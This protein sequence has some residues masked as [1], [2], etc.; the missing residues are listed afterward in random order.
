MPNRR[1]LARRKNL[2]SLGARFVSDASTG[3]ALRYFTD[4]HVGIRRISVGKRFIY[5][6][7]HGRRVRDRETLHRI[8]SLVIPPAWID[9]WISPLANG[10]LQSTGRDSRGRKQYL[11]HPRWREV[12]DAAKFDRLLNFAGRLPRLR[13]RLRRDLASKGISREKVL[14]TVVRLLELTSIRVGNEEYARNNGSFGLTT[15]RNHHAQ[16]N[17]ESIR[18]QFRGKSGKFHS[19]SITNP[20]LARVVRKC[21]ELPGHEL[22]EYVDDKGELHEINSGDVNAYLRDVMGEDFTAKD[23]RTWAGTLLASEYL[24]R[25]GACKTMAESNR[26]VKKM[27]KSVAERLGNTPTVCRKSYIHPI[28]IESASQSLRNNASHTNGNGDLRSIQGLHADEAALL[29]LL[30]RAGR[31]SST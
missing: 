24:R 17:G 22:F 19:V 7:P 6:D 2:R 31:R 16:V 9:V 28:V 30:K 18:F 15:F 21:Q 4:R 12:R 29:G 5:R 25:H 27:V 14:A 3:G 23:F 20:R 11:Y 1:G 13:R 10:H 8:R 26:T